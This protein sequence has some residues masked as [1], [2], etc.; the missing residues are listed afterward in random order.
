MDTDEDDSRDDS[1]V[2]CRSQSH[3]GDDPCRQVERPHFL[4][5]P[6]DKNAAKKRSLSL[7]HR[8]VKNALVRSKTPSGETKSSVLLPRRRRCKSLERPHRSSDNFV[9][10]HL[11]QSAPTTS[12]ILEWEESAATRSESED[13]EDDEPPKRTMFELIMNNTLAFGIEYCYATET[14]LVTPILLR[15][16]LPDSL[17]SL[18]W[19]ISPILGFI[20]QPVIGSTSDR[21]TCSWGRRRP[22]VFALCIGVMIG[23]T[24]LLNGNDIGK[25]ITE[26]QTD[27][28]ASIVLTIVGVVM[29]DFC[30]DSSDSP[31]RAYMID[32]CNSD[33]LEK[34]LNLHAMLGGLGGG[35][36]Y[37]MA[38]ISWE[39]TKLGQLLGGH[40]R[41]VFIFNIIVCFVTFLPTLFSIKEIPLKSSSSALKATEESSLP[42]SIGPSSTYGSINQTPE[43]IVEVN[44]YDRRNS[45][46]GYTESEET[47]LPPRTLSD[48]DSDDDH[49]K[50]HVTRSR[51]RT[52]SS[53]SRTDS[54]EV[55][56]TLVKID[57]KV[58]KIES[59]VESMEHSVK[60]IERKVTDLESSIKSLQDFSTLPPVKE[61]RRSS[62]HSSNSSDEPTSVWQLMK[63]IIFMPG[64]LRRLCLNHF[65]G[66]FGVVS[67][68]LFFTDFVGQVVYN[69]DPKAELNTT[70]RDNYD[71]GVKMGCWGMCIFAFSAAI[72]GFLFERIL[73]YVS[74]RTAYV[75]GE[76]VFA[77]GIGLMSI[78]N[79]NVYVTLSMCSTVG[80]MFTTITTLPFTIVSEFHDC[81]SYV[82]GS[83]KGARGLG[84]DISSLS[85]QIFLA[86]IL[87]SV[88]LGTVIRATGSHLAI[89]LF[90]SGAGFLAAF[91]SALIVVY[92][93]PEPSDE[94]EPLIRNDDA[95]A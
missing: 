56:R 50:K 14:A 47:P 49:S 91:C 59:N 93:V 20:F 57:K 87:V 45:Y 85:C 66:W 76:L 39:K 34:G 29:L 21:C 10:P 44:H 80:I 40:Y 86:Q 77:V 32:V 41:V 8:T 71:D 36:S 68:L 15:I 43:L 60:N 74:I 38:G 81:D 16:G 63:S 7:G 48:S 90:A 79:N 78:F 75:G 67:Y 42:T 12:V 25:A 30:A 18:T 92:E 58:G 3:P 54:P 6:G 69:G 11:A 70:A 17:Y 26:L 27:N 31:A 65:F 4:Q 37:I 95:V 53:S 72:Y 5:L 73:N 89:V 62:Q 52:R 1:P 24:L 94:V 84:T 64:I 46:H 22:F 28:V 35:I 19:F 61:T 9:S 2:F 82:Y 83:D 23:L 55:K 88:L 51:T 33:D 13:S